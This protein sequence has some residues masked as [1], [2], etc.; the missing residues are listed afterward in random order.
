[1]YDK[2]DVI[3]RMLSL[4]QLIIS[5]QKRSRN[6]AG[7]KRLHSLIE[8]IKGVGMVQGATLD[9]DDG[10]YFLIDGASWQQACKEL[11]HAITPN[12][13]MWEET[14]FFAFLESLLRDSDKQKATSKK[15]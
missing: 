4:D 3:S 5:Q 12:F 10:R 15:P 2:E 7:L 11:K 9:P 8:N 6:S 1:M 14:D 13:I